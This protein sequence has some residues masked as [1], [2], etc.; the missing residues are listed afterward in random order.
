MKLINWALPKGRAIRYIFFTIPQSYIVKKDAA[1]IPSASF[2][3]IGKFF[4]Q[5][6]IT[7]IDKKQLNSTLQ[8]LLT[9]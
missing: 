6:A 2:V 7:A 1:A 8:S 3:K 5:N 9:S 4:L